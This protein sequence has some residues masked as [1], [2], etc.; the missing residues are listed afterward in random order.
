MAAGD[1]AALGL[2]ISPQG[3]LHLHEEEGGLPLEQATV[4]HLRAAFATS[5]GHG[6]LELGAAYVDAALPPSLGYF[7]D[8]GRIFMGRLCGT[9][10]LEASRAEVSLPAPREELAALARAAPPIAGGEYIDAALLE[11]LWRALE[12]ALRDQIRVWKGPVEAWLAA[13]HPAWHTVG[14]VCFHLAENRRDAERPFA[15]LATYTTGLSVAA[16]T[17]HLPLGQA[18]TEFARDRAALLSLLQPV[19]RAAKGSVLARE[20]LDSREL[21]H[22]LA[23]TAQEAYRLLREIPVLEA[24]GVLVRIPDWWKARPRVRIQATIGNSAPSALGLEGLLD[25]QIG[26]SLDG[27]PLTEAEWRAL[28]EREKAG[29]HL[30]LIRGKWVEVDPERLKAA[31]AHF[32]QVQRSAGGD[33]LTLLEGMRLLAGARPVDQELPG[34][35]ESHEWAQVGAGAWLTATLAEMRSAGGSTAIVNRIEGDLRAELRPYQRVGVGWLQLLDRLGLGA[36]LADDMGLGKTL[37]VIG[38]LLILRRERP[39]PRSLLVVPASL[40]GNWQAE[41]ERFAPSLRAIVAHPSQAPAAEL[42][43]GAPA[44]LAD[45]DL[46]ITTYGSLLRQPWLR[47]TRW[48]LLV[49]DE[50]QAIKNPSAKQT[51]AAKALAGRSRVALTG[52]PVE[53]RLSDLWSLFDF[54]N[55]GL[56]GSAKAF[57]DLAKRLAAPG[58]PGYRPLRDLCR[59]YILRRLKTD[60]GV[61][62]DLPDKTEL[63]AF[64]SLSR[65]QAALYPQAVD[66]LAADLQRADGMKRRGVIL[67]Y[68]MRFKQIC[69]HPAHWLKEEA[70]AEGESGKLA[71]LR[72]L[73]EP[74]ASRQ[75]KALCF[76]QFREAT[77]P[78][79]DF[80]GRVFGRPGLVLHGETPVSQ[81]RALVERFQTDDDVPFFVL[82]VKAGGTGLNLTA[83]SHVIHF[84][85]WW[86]PAVEDQATDRAYRIGQRRNVLVH[87]FVCRGTVEERID[88]LIEGKRALSRELL[89]GGGEALLTEMGDRELIDLVSLDIRQALG[90]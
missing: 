45:A 83:A 16:R 82:S 52:T 8:L 78:L 21:F 76:T 60:P 41:I 73:C 86:N 62:D 26:A 56:L 1:G 14:R 63:V 38:L 61:A 6:L 28:L 44:G 2:R 77:A 37:Q 87:K 3:R 24:A 66:G 49:L 40:L 64:C 65:R 71:R 81:R 42:K 53:N 80:L 10:D 89:A 68:L 36:C 47:E 55:P 15:F 67:A 58:G 5:T 57:G 35:G 48:R 12:Q 90:D 7:R 39:R 74:I 33:G 79:S 51:R 31:L 84:D 32:R 18:L 88:R 25:F 34:L 85:R 72:E 23:W 13:K 43:A 29:G 19:E 30:A 20:L 9:P 4:E 54:L 27:E 70:W 22:P 50:A 59:P 69:N 11:T 46:V 75:E 17:R